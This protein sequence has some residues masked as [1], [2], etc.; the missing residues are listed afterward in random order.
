MKTSTVY[1][2]HPIS[3]V[4]VIK[5]GKWCRD[6]PI[7]RISLKWMHRDNRVVGGVQQCDRRTPRGNISIV[8]KCVWSRIVDEN[9]CRR[10]II[11]SWTWSISLTEKVANEI[12]LRIKY[13]RKVK[14]DSH[15]SK[16]MFTEFWQAACVRLSNELCAISAWEGWQDG[17][18]YIDQSRTIFPARGSTETRSAASWIYIMP[19]ISFRAF[20]NSRWINVQFDPGN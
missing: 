5:E 13:K 3:T 15:W 14:Y 11:I 10:H 6:S 16:N 19:I 7:E 8:I 4:R 20:Q 2:I 9:R 1:L 17:S 12:M 18:L